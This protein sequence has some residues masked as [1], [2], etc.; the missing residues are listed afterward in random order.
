MRFE[1]LMNLRIREMNNLRILETLH[2]KLS[3]IYNSKF[4]KLG[5][6]NPTTIEGIIEEFPLLQE[7][8]NLGKDIE[9]LAEL[10]KIQE[11]YLADI[12]NMEIAFDIKREGKE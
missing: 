4:H 7:I 8:G 3:D 10:I 1:D 2:E 12:N 9:K 5:D 6:I 11:V